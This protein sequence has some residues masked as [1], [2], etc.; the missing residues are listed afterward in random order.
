MKPYFGFTLISGVAKFSLL[1]ILALTSKICDMYFGH[2][3]NGNDWSSPNPEMSVV[4]KATEVAP[5]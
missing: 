5:F 1:G 3:Q 4:V 2:P